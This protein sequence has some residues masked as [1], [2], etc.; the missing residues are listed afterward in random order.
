MQGSCNKCFSVSERRL[1]LWNN[2]SKRSKFDECWCFSS[3]WNIYSSLLSLL[4]SVIFI[5]G[6]GRTNTFFE[7]WRKNLNFPGLTKVIFLPT[8]VLKS[9]YR[10]FKKILVLHC[11]MCKAKFRLTRKLVRQKSRNYIWVTCFSLVNSWLCDP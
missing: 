2:S 7:T 10:T 9:K 5:R 4:L 8:S 6:F 3:D 11:F 1:T